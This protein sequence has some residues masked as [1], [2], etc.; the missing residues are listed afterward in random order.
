ETFEQGYARAMET[1]VWDLQVRIRWPDGSV[2]WIYDRGR[3]YYDE[4]HQPLRM[5]A[6]T[7][8]IT[9]RR[10]GEE[11][12]RESAERFRA[13]ADLV[14]D[15]LWSND[16]RGWTEWYNKRWLEYTGQ[17]MEEAQGYGWLDVIHPDDR[18]TSVRNF[19]AALDG[20]EP[21]RQEHRIRGRDGVYRW[22][23]ARAEPVRDADS[24]ILCW[25]GAATDIDDVR[26]TEQ[27]L[28]ES[29]ARLRAMFEQATVGIV[30]VSLDRRLLLVNPGFCAIVGYTADEACGMAVSDITHPDDDEVEHTLSLQLVAGDISGYVL[31]KRYIR[32]DGSLVW[33]QMTGA[34]VRTPSGEPLYT[35][36]IIEDITERKQVEA[37]RE[38]LLQEA[39]QAR[40]V[41]E[42]AVQMRDQ[43][44]SIASHEL[45][46]TLTSLVGYTSMLQA[47]MAGETSA[48]A[49]T[50]RQLSAIARQ[51]NR[52]NLLIGRLLDVSR[53]QGGQ[54]TVE[55]QP[56]ELGALVAHVVEEFRLMLPHG[57]P[58]TVALAHPDEPVEVLG[59]AARMEE[60]LQNLLSN[61]VKYSPDGGTIR[62]G[63]AR[64]D[65]EAVLEVADEGIGIPA[66]A[67]EQLFEPFFR[68]GNV[69]PRT[70]GFG[71]G[72]YIVQEIV[73]RH[74]GRV[75]V[76]STEG[77]GTTFRVIVPLAE[78]VVIS[79]QWSVVG[80]Q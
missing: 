3:V 27:A 6:V 58:H 75:E 76:E 13:I 14:P 55:R 1:G 42:A 20:G 11:A 47:R 30:Q 71:L 67:R 60:V 61:A 24:R 73:Q 22:F 28:R 12:L 15:L 19:Q 44:L 37:E 45:R 66:E 43:F 69:G 41:A 7:L 70:S 23:L 32:K 74:G 62:V 38:R 40:Q 56:V 8:D 50:Q 64:Q 35:L 31:E 33:G 36:A 39:E 48:D 77:Q 68:A 29:E 63:V 51:A 17:T 21:L 80:D 25:Y 26:R 78:D 57:A 53:L 54:F 18:E 16:P 72:L 2:H 34:L 5:A 9:E 49:M 52:L 4:R 10:R 79:D 46:T 59:D 65:G